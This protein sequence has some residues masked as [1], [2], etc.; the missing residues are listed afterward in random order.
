MAELDQTEVFAPSALLLSGNIV[1]AGAHDT[2]FGLG[3]VT[4]KT[5]FRLQTVA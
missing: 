2:D 5:F 1:K 3:V 4:L